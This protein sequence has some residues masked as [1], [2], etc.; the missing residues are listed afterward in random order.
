MRRPG[1]GAPGR[2][3]RSYRQQLGR[4]RHGDAAGRRSRRAGRRTACPGGSRL[5]RRSFAVAPDG[6]SGAF[7]TI[8]SGGRLRPSG[9]GGPNPKG[10]PCGVAPPIEIR[11][12]DPRPEPA[13]ERHPRRPILGLGRWS[14]SSATRQGAG[15]VRRGSRPDDHHAGIRR[16]RKARGMQAGPEA[17]GGRDCGRRN[18]VRKLPGVGRG[19][20]RGREP[21]ESPGRRDVSSRINAVIPPMPG[22]TP[23]GPGADDGNDC[24]VKGTRGER[25]LV[26]EPAPGKAG[27]ELARPGDGAAVPV[28]GLLHPPGQ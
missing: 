22:S 20:H 13:G 4:V 23:P 25:D 24:E 2:P 6:N 5:G 16:R 3:P 18:P 1:S 11:S 15:G 28:N 9:D 8:G 7:T 14:I 21:R 27:P 26:E 10:V 12:R 17:E 19:W